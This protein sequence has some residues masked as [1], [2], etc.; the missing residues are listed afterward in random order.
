MFTKIMIAI[1]ELMIKKSMPSVYAAV[2]TK[3]RRVKNM[4]TIRN[5]SRKKTKG[6]RQCQWKGFVTY[7]LLP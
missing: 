5:T 6:N 7:D 1:V 2:I 3:N 4:V